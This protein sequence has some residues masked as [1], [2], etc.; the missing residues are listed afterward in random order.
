MKI[1]VTGANGYIGS[2]VVNSL[3]ECKNIEVIC[4]DIDNSHIDKRA[5]F[6]KFDILNS[7]ISNTNLY[8][9]FKKPDICIHL[10][11][12]DGF[13]HNSD[14]H[15]LDLSH[16]YSFLENMVSNGLRSIAIMGTM[17][18]VG[19]REGAIDENTPCNPTNL[20]GVSKNALRKATQ[21]LC[22]KYNCTWKWLRAYYIYGNDDFGASIFCKI[23]KTYNNGGKEF[24]LTK[25]TNKFDFIE[26]NELA[27]FISLT[28]LQDKVNGIINVCSGKPVSL[29][30]KIIE[31]T[32]INNINLK[33]NWGVFPERESESPCIYGDRTKLDMILEN[34]NKTKI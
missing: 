30:E 11:W 6:I 1:L 9:Y 31:Y 13:V 23:R 24:N 26:I 16:H 10:A 20:Y 7:D 32:K 25:G 3:L 34:Y 29:K 2:K 27:K 33:L 14:K 21:I 22:Q 15:V 4:V 19:Y 5:S 12:R 18:E 28:I 17:H 8:E